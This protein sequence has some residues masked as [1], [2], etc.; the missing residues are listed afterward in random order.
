MHILLCTFAVG[1]PDG[2][3]SSS[4]GV[5]LA[6]DGPEIRLSAR[7]QAS[8]SEMTVRLPPGTV[9]SAGIPAPLTKAGM[10]QAVFDGAWLGEGVHT[11]AW[12]GQPIAPGIRRQ[13][14]LYVSG[15]ALR[16]FEQAAGEPEPRWIAPPKGLGQVVVSFLVAAAGGCSESVEGA[17]EELLGQGALA[18]GRT[19]CVRA[20]REEFISPFQKAGLFTALRKRPPPPIS[21]AAAWRD[22]TRVLF[23]CDLDGTG[24]MVE[25]PGDLFRTRANY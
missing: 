16:K 13:L 2:P 12:P 14:S 21:Q 22:G 5:S 25:Q 24:L 10:R 1:L 19:V 17:G 18:D 6:D 20:R 8:R 3:R 9:A 15:S 11:A 4:F 7:T 23:A